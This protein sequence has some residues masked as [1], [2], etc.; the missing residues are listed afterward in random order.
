MRLCNRCRHDLRRRLERLGILRNEDRIVGQFGPGCA[1]VRKCCR[2][3]A[4]GRKRAAQHVGGHV[5]D[6]L[7]RFPFDPRRRTA[8]HL[9]VEFPER[10]NAGKI[11]ILYIAA[12]G[13][14][15][16]VVVHAPGD[17]GGDHGRLYP[18]PVVGHRPAGELGFILQDARRH[19][20]QPAIARDVFVIRAEQVECETK[21]Q[22]VARR[23][24]HPGGLEAFDLHQIARPLYAAARIITQVA[25]LR[26]PDAGQPFEARKIGPQTR[27]AEQLGNRRRGK[28]RD[29]QPV[30]L[31]DLGHKVRPDDT[32]GAGPVLDDDS[33]IAR[34]IPRQML[35]Q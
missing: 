18:A 11:G 20:R 6:H 32:A 22:I 4:L 15:R 31:G 29:G 7:Q 14:D 24:A 27:I 8:P 5:I 17:T 34:D 26:L 3:R 28:D 30:R 33:R 16:S 13:Q 25:Y 21:S 10:R 2:R 35:S 19:L 12:I 23:I 9:G 1:Q